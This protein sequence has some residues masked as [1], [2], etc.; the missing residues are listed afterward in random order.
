MAEATVVSH[1][2]DSPQVPQMRQNTAKSRYPLWIRPRPGR[3]GRRT[4]RAARR[5]ARSDGALPTVVARWK[6]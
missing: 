3:A 4:A 2:S 1:T 5:G 6:G